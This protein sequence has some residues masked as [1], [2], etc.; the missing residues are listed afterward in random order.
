MNT[1]LIMTA[2]AITLGVAALA[3]TFIPEEI[4]KLL[5]LEVSRSL[6]LL[7]QIVGASYFGFA[8]LNWMSR[9]NVIGGIY[10]KPIAV[11]NF[12]HF[13]IG[14]MALVKALFSNAALSSLLWLIA[15][16]YL[17]FAV[18]FGWLFYKNPSGKKQ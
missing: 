8:M 9:N 2:S 4:L 16:I 5:Q 6:I 7:L 11:A 14:A 17:L 18:I 12:A 15:I 1:K 10:N 13:F 3:F